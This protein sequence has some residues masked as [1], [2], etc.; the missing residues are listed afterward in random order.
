MGL[1]LVANQYVSTAVSAPMPTRVEVGRERKNWL[2]SSIS[3]ILRPLIISWACI[4]SIRVELSS[5]Q[6]ERY[7]MSEVR[8]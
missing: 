8:W 3:G 1:G 5:A 6:Q 2:M 7:S 4:F